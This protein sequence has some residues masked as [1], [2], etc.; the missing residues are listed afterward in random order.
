ML[1]IGASKV[2]VNLLFPNPDGSTACAVVIHE[3]T[4]TG[5]R[6]II[7]ANLGDS[8]AI[9]SRNGTAID[10]T[11]DH[12][13]NNKLEKERIEALGGSVDWC[14]ELDNHGEPVVDTGV[15]RINGNLALSRAIGDRSER[16]FISSTP[17]ICYNVVDEDFDTFVL[18]ATDGLF[19]VMTS[20][21]VISLIHEKMDNASCEQSEYIR[22]NMA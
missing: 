1:F 22:K 20:Q 5:K 12:K 15:Y 11:E 17:D 14:G 9:L 19:D 21:E 13:P 4:T 2:R 18:L 8:R 3:N 6:S 7:S 16:P 10:L